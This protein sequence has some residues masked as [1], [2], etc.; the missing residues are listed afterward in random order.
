METNSEQLKQINKLLWEQKFIIYQPVKSKGYC[1][2]IKS[3]RF[4]SWIFKGS[5]SKNLLKQ[6]IAFNPEY[7]CIAQ[8]QDS[9]GCRQFIPFKTWDDCWTAYQHTGYYK[10]FLHEVIISN[11]PCKPYLD[12]EWIEENATKN[13]HCEFIDQLK[14]DLKYIFDNRYGLEL[15]DQYILITQSHRENKVSFH[16][17]I[18]ILINNCYYAYAT[19]RAKHQ[20]SAWDLYIALIN[21][22]RPLYESKIDKSVYSLDREFR[23]VY[24]TKHGQIT[25]FSPIIDT[26]DRFV[27][28]Y[29][30]YLITHFDPLCDIKIIQTPEYIPAKVI[31][32]L[33]DGG[34]LNDYKGHHTNDYN[35]DILTR[36]YELLQFIHPTAK[37]TNKTPN[38]NGWR[39]SYTDKSELCYTGHTH[40]SNGFCV[41][42][43][44]NNGDIYMYCYSSKC[45]RLY[46]L[47]NLHYDNTWQQDALLINQQYLE[48]QTEIKLN[49]IFKS[50]DNKLTGFLNQ[51]IDKGGCY[52][53]RSRMGTGKTQVLKK[54]IT[55]KFDNKR[56]LYLSHRQT[57]THNI[58][59]SLKE[60]SFYNYLDSKQNLEAHDR[61]I[62]QIDS[63]PRLVGYEN[64]LYYYDLIVMD[65]IESLLAHLNSPTLTDKRSLV[66]LI[67]G[68]LIKNAKWVLSMDADFGNRSY[69]FLTQIREQ[70]KIIIN[71][72][73]SIKKKFMFTN[74]YDLQCHQL[75]EDL[76]NKK[77]IAIICLSKN[78]LDELYEKIIGTIKSIKIIRYTSMTDD[79]QKMELTN[80]N[81]IWTNFQCLLYSPTIEA[82]VDF[83]KEH[84]NKIYCFLTG[85]S[86]SPR[87]FLQMIGRIR[88]ITDNKVR[89]FCDKTMKFEDK[90]CY[91]PPVNEVEQIM[92]NKNH[93]ANNNKFTKVDE[94][95]SQLVIKSDAFTSTFAYNYLEN[96]EKQVHF[97]T[98][99]KELIIEKN[100]EYINEDAGE[101]DNANNANTADNVNENVKSASSIDSTIEEPAIDI[102]D[103]LQAS[104]CN[105]SKKTVEMDEL[106]EIPFISDIEMADLTV[107]QNKNLLTRNDKLALRKYWL[108]KKFHISQD[109]FTMEFLLNWYGK[110]HIFDN[111]QYA[112]GNKKIDDSNDPYLNQLRQKINYLETILK[113]Y[114]FNGLNDD[115]E[116]EK[117]D[118]METR[119]KNSKLLEWDNYRKLMMCFGKRLLQKEKNKFTVAKFTKISDSVLN[120]FGM[121][122]KSTRK[123]KRCNEGRI[124]IIKYKLIETRNGS[125]KNTSEI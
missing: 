25:M 71:Q 114:G 95:S 18:N 33:K 99:L 105:T 10:R 117:D 81:Q 17:V 76:K 14:I 38:D 75:I 72:Y 5:G 79:E 49:D 90:N 115:A 46:K 24:S 43:K 50:T 15:K 111:L 39:F 36:I 11:R 113:V 51:F 102:Y 82:G 73:H 98:I 31:K 89:C 41:Y 118:V 19:N 26:S 7:K 66:C 20:Q 63:L 16:I 58:Y 109:E 57:F 28:N 55:A 6:F 108:M 69:N 32:H 74:N 59:G 64:K 94:R 8:I 45:G 103:G 1:N 65:E 87:S 88:T 34:R 119:M 2:V 35:D 120:E 40:K 78:V 104:T 91:I 125:K 37:F 80:V 112:L 101:L 93:I 53:I 121:G 47:G 123:Q 61:L 68:E 84:F 62:L 67:L 83:N 56:I 70:P 13:N 30:D 23:A 60:L 97:L 22:N 96:Y 3:K 52:V 116:T 42:I 110:E 27:N 54:L 4:N 9:G 106:L 48:Y 92:I 77:N 85:G 86:C 122:L 44:P 100:W 29:L 124:Y 107:K 21:L 12:I